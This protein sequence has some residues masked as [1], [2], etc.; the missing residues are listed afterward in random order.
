MS[1]IRT[2]GKIKK[3]GDNS[4]SSKMPSPEPLLSWESRAAAPTL[5]VL[6]QQ[7]QPEPR[8]LLEVFALILVLCLSREVI[9]A[10]KMQQDQQQFPHQDWNLYNVCYLTPQPHKSLLKAL[11]EHPQKSKAVLI[12]SELSPNENASETPVKLIS[13][14]VLNPPDCYFSQQLEF[15]KSCGLMHRFLLQRPIKK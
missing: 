7:W 12:N 4:A 10:L 3:K 1:W 9:P 14:T 2:T 11:K 13:S 8:E 15:R 5:P 6:S